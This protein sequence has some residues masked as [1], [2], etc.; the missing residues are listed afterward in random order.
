MRMSAERADESWSDALQ[1]AQD[2]CRAALTDGAPPPRTTLMERVLAAAVM[3]DE[4]ALQDLRA[5]GARDEDAFLIDWA[6]FWAFGAE[7][8]GGLPPPAAPV[9]NWAGEQAWMQYRRRTAAARSSADQGLAA[10]DYS[11]GPLRI[12]AQVNGVE[13]HFILDTG[14]STSVIRP[15]FAARAK[16]VADGPERVVWDGAGA[17][18]VFVS[19]R[20]DRFQ[21]GTWWS[22]NLPLDILELNTA[23][24]ADGILSPFDLFDRNS[25]TFDGPRARLLVGQDDVV[26]KIPVFWSEGVP[27]LRVRTENGAHLM[28]LDT[29][30]GGTLIL[31]DGLDQPHFDTATAIGS[32]PI[33][34]LGDITLTPVGCPPFSDVLYAKPR[35]PTRLRP[36]PRLFD[37]YLG[38]T[39][40]S[41][42]QVTFPKQRGLIHV[43]LPK[44]TS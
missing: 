5:P 28:L 20:A 14:A 29:G 38:I 25:V 18:G 34:R 31:S 19:A 1:A 22:R 26:P 9:S 8:S 39:W 44:E 17:S 21:T 36:L 3:S 15:D 16:V 7:W 11:N 6:G 42:H 40:F 10:L 12:S 30:A 43:A 4:A 23:L 24:D 27:S 32:A 13:G 35:G 2:R 37:G 41:R 33:A